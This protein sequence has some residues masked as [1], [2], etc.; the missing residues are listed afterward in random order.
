MAIRAPAWKVSECGDDRLY[1]DAWGCLPLPADRTECDTPFRNPRWSDYDALIP[2]DPQRVRHT[3]DV[4]EP[5]RDER[6]LQYATIIKSDRP[7]SLMVRPADAS[8]IARQLYDK[9][10]HDPFLLADVSSR[11]ILFQRS[12]EF[13]V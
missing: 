1:V 7:K 5:R 9:V 6:D 10:Q 2:A 11:V 12:H 8:G 13:V 3:V 4:V